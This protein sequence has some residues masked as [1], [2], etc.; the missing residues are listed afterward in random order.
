MLGCATSSLEGFFH[1]FVRDPFAANES[2]YRKI[3]PEEI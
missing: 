3:D 1:G 2:H